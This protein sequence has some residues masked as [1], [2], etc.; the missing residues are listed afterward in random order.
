MAKVIAKPRPELSEF[1]PRI[2]VLQINPEK[3][4]VVIGPG[5]K[6]IKKITEETGVQIDIE[7]DG[8]VLITATDPEGARKAKE[9]INQLT[10]EIEVGDVF[11]G[12]VMRILPFGA[13]VEMVPGKE[14]LVHIS[15]IAPR[16]LSRVEDGVKI[17]EE[18]WV[19][20]VEID[21]MGRYNLSIKAVTEQD[22]QNRK[23]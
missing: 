15:Q 5:G 9:I 1:A 19:K 3:I 23:N 2:T 20:V 10:M 18:V 22:K 16:R 6:T 7:D 4:G 13:F 17:G 8:K 11:L 12:K 21:D 14:G